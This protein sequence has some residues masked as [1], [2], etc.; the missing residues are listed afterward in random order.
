MSLSDLAA[1]ALFGVALPPSRY[2]VGLALGEVELKASGYERVSA[3]R[4]TWRVD[5]SRATV[6]VTF[7]PFSDNVEFD[8]TLLITD[9]STERLPVIGG[10]IRLAEGMYLEHEVIVSFSEGANL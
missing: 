8:S 10:P 3:P 9:S 7:G 4:T 5:G 2:Q 6:T 1:E